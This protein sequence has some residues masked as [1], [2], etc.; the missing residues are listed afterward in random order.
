MQTQGTEMTAVLFL[1]VALCTL[2]FIAILAMLAKG[3]GAGTVRPTR[4]SRR[5]ALRT[6]VL[7]AVVVPE[8]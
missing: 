3:I 7:A 5:I 1:N 6:A 8:V 4:R 2:V